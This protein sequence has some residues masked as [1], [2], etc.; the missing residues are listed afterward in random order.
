[1]CKPT[2]SHLLETIVNRKKNSFF[3]SFL[4][5]MIPKRKQH[6]YI[7]TMDNEKDDSGN[8]KKVDEVREGGEGL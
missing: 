5:L 1:M 4:Y 2:G 6:C 8:E 3:F 7:Y